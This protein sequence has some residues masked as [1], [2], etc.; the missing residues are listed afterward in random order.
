MATTETATDERLIRQL[1]DEWAKAL[2]SKDIDAVMA[3]YTPDFV[4]FDLAPPLQVCGTEAHRKGFEAWFPTFD[5]PIGHEAHQLSITVG[6]N[7]A[8]SHCLNRITG[9]RTNGEHTDVWVRATVGFRKI[10]GRWFAAHEHVSVPFYMDGSDKA[11]ID[12]KP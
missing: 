2:R 1:I 5:G 4:A 3:A 8:F 6:E 7:V 10:S 11:A 9:K 12:L